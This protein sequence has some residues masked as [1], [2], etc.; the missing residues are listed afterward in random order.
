MNKLQTTVFII[1]ATFFIV[2]PL[3][4][5]VSLSW[6]I[7][8]LPI[9]LLIW[10]NL[11]SISASKHKIFMAGLVCSAIGDTL[12]DIDR[13]QFFVF[14]LGAFL[15]AHL[16]YIISLTPLQNILKSKVSLSLVIAY[17]VYALV[18]FSFIQPGLS[19]LLIPVSIYMSVLMLMGIFTL[20]SKQSN[21]WLVMGGI[22]F[23][24][25]DSLLG[26]DKFYS[27]IPL[28]GILIMISYYFAQYAL[29]K[30]IFYRKTN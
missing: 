3:M 13:T 15:V 9:F 4:G 8:I 6:L 10:V 26:F 11:K 22:S 14:G 20:L 28:A 30:G 5:I 12:L 29:V 18:M 17:L 19:T 2:S 21:L 7:K 24:I 16:F 25:S 23:I 27:P 1:L